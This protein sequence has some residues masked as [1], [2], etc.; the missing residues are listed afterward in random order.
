MVQLKTSFCSQQ[1][2][3]SFSCNIGQNFLEC[4]DQLLKIRFSDGERTSKCVAT[5]L[6]TLEAIL[7]VDNHDCEKSFAAI[8]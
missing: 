2:G 4:R 7:A 6:S 1:I 5:L 3:A 8:F